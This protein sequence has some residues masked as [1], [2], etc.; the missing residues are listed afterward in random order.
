M[1]LSQDALQ[2]RRRYQRQWREKNPDKNREYQRTF[3]ER[4]AEIYSAEQKSID[5]KAETQKLRTNG[6]TQREIAKQLNISVGSVNKYLNRNEQ[7]TSI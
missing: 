3:W 7:M 2:G 6:L 1:E 5:L 4:K